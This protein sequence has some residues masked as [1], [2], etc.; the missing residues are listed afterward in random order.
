AQLA[1][2]IDDPVGLEAVCLRLKLVGRT[3]IPRQLRMK[4][5]NQLIEDYRSNIGTAIVYVEKLEDEVRPDI[6]LHALAR[7][8]SPPGILARLMLAL[9]SGELNQEERDLLRTVQAKLRD[10]HGARPYL[11]LSAI[12]LAPDEMAA[13][14][15]LR[16][17]GWDLLNALITQQESA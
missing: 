5:G 10:V 12:D 13:Q 9:E 3:N 16:Q 11:P 2:H 6:D 17:A 1:V 7:E 14:V 8:S 15:Y 4:L